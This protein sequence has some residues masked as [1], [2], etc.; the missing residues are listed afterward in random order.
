LV[1]DFAPSTPSSV[2]ELTGRVE[3]DDSVVAAKSYRILRF[4]REA[5][6][7]PAMTAG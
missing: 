3:G 6:K 5:M 7:R 4:L 2:V 1:G